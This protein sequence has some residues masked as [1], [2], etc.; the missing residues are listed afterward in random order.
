MSWVRLRTFPRIEIAGTLIVLVLAFVP[1]TAA[2]GKPDCNDGADNDGDGAADFPDDPGCSRRG[3]ASEQGADACD[4]GLD[5]DQDG[6]VD[7]AQDAG[8]SG[9]TDATE[10][11]EYADFQALPANLTGLEIQAFGDAAPG[12]R[13]RAWGDFAFV[14]TDSDT[15]GVVIFDVSEP[16]HPTRAGAIDVRPGRTYEGLEV[17]YYEG[18]DRTVVAVNLIPEDVRANVDSSGPIGFWD[19]TDPA[20]PFELARVNVTAHIFGAHPSTH[21]VYNNRRES[22]STMEVIDA[23]DPDD[24][25][26]AARV[27]IPPFAR[28]GTFVGF[29]PLYPNCH[30]ITVDAAAARMYCASDRLTL[31]FDISDPLDP[32]LLTAMGQIGPEGVMCCSHTYA[33]P[34]LDGRYLAVSEEIGDCVEMP[35]G[36]VWPYGKIVIF[37]LQTSPPSFVTSVMVPADRTGVCVFAPTQG[38]EVGAGTGML[39][40]GWEKAGLVLVDASDPLHPL[41]ADSDLSA[42]EEGRDAYYYRGLVFAAGA[43]GGLQVAVPHSGLGNALPPPC[44]N[45]SIAQILCA[46]TTDEVGG[47]VVAFLM[48]SAN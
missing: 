33:V 14:T 40:F 25:H 44:P 38:S 45:G 22:L 6:T 29:P 1:A 21:M 31:V 41:I 46:P 42:G 48:G 9:P 24:I 8:C 10:T 36:T 19:V 34:F 20:A 11:L 3:D 26:L 13:V 28:D 39:A 18:I 47:L 2:E 27:P 30:G 7:V 23:S 35:E 5:N 43:V 17:L 32:V 16:L 4:D 15:E 12:F 37:D